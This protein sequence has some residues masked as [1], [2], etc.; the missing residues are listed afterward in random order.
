MLKQC[1]MKK[2]FFSIS[3]L[4]FV[5]YLLSCN[6]TNTGTTAQNGDNALPELKSIFINGDS[7]HYIDIGKGEPVVF[8]HGSLDDYRAW[9][10]EMDTFA[11]NHRVIAYSRRYA[12]PANQVWNDSA[13]Y[14]VRIHANDLTTL[15][16]S[17]KLGPVHLVGH[18]YGAYTTLLTAMEHPELVKTLTLG[19]PPLLPL[20][21]SA[22]GGDTIEYNFMNRSVAPAA[23]AFKAGNDEKAIAVFVGGV[24]GDSA[25]YS[26]IPPEGRDM[27]RANVLELRGAVLSKKSPFPP[28]TCSDLKKINIPVLLLTGEK[29]V[30]LFSVITDEL[31][32]CLPNKEKTVLPGATHGL[33]FDNP[34]DFNR[35]VLGFIDRH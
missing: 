28:V 23:E 33:Q 22:A 19:E 11:K 35:I 31:N 7:I 26:T 3:V 29:T 16:K 13:D 12:Y 34:G 10:M 30:M 32:Q 17:L 27:M 20:L 5:F 14:S 4:L 18:S 9:Q 24:I 25:A 6:N 21:K 15:I 1:D 2:N 8:V